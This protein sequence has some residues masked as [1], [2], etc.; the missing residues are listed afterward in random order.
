MSIE[1][2]RQS[3]VEVNSRLDDIL[4]HTDRARELLEEA[5]RELVAVQS[6]AEPWLPSQFPAAL[7]GIQTQRERIAGIG[8]LLDAYAARL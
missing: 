4:A 3:L 7:E 1:A 8:E 6:Q 5:R 2:L